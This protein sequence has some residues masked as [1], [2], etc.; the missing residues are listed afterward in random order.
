MLTVRP[1]SPVLC[2]TACRIRSAAALASPGPAPA[3]STPSS[4]PVSATSSEN[5][6][7][8]ACRF[9]NPVTL[10]PANNASSCD[11]SNPIG[12]MIDSTG[13]A[14]G[15][16]WIRSTGYSRHVQRSI[17]ATFRRVS[18][19]DFLYY[20]DY[21]TLSPTA[22]DRAAAAAQCDVYWRNGRPP[23]NRNQSYCSQIFFKSGDVVNGPLHTED[24]PA[25]C[26]NPVVRPKQIGP[27]RGRGS[28]TGALQPG[29]RKLQRQP[30]LHRDLRDRRQ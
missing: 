17:V 8:N 28:R 10:L 30:D 19:V 4:P 1:S 27:D 26:G 3:I 11:T 22:S 18:F 6:S 9:H 7:S 5:R 20:S 24:E 25:I 2:S 29:Q 12:T 16:F 13:P 15:T 21:E 14:A 23:A